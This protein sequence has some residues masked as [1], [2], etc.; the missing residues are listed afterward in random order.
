MSLNENEIT[1]K[2]LMELR[3][4]LESQFDLIQETGNSDISDKIKEMFN[5][6]LNDLDVEIDDLLNKVN[7]K[8]ELLSD[9]ETNQKIVPTYNY[10]SDSGFDLFNVGP[11]IV[12]QPFSR[13][14]IPT[15]IKL[16]IPKGFEI[17]VRSKS[18]LA[19]NQ[20]LFVLNSPGTVDQ[21]YTGEIKVILYNSTTEPINVSNMMK[22]GQ[23]VLCPVVSGSRVLLVNKKVED[24]DRSDNGFG[25]T[26]I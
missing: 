3:Q 17:Q 21:G 25:S 10:P 1:I 14:L 19:L 16:D 4:Q 11:H 26:G 2:E 18:G 24:K 9:D 6:D 22:V 12:I 7:L 15:G 20:G 8:F 13:T 23:A 5:I